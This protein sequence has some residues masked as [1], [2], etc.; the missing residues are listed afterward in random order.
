MQLDS[1]FSPL[2][3]KGQSIHHICANNKASVMFSKKTIYNYVDAGI[4]TARNIDMPRKARF[5][6][7]KSRHDSF[8]V[9]KTCRIGRTYKDFQLFMK[10]HPDSP[11]V[12]IDS[13]EGKK[14]EKVLLTIHFVKAEF[15]LAFLRERNTASSVS[16]IFEKLYQ[17]LGA[18]VFKKLFPL[19]LTD[20]GSEFSD[21]ESIERDADG[22]MR[23]RVFYCDPSAPHQ[24]GA[25]ENNHGFIR[26]V[27]PKGTSFEDLTQE[28]TDR[29]MCHIN[30]YCRANLGN[31]SPH[32]MF[33]LF[34][35]Q[36]VLD[37][38]GAVLI[39]PNDITL[40]PELLK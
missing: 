33:H 28:S 20:N 36:D 29:M 12:E 1:L 23:T 30:S 40:R 11:V 16:V 26:R 22:N 5:R 39:S 31:H 3:K 21:P 2:L 38:L 7:R 13:V 19:I 37:A 4:F 15:M 14:G 6:V 10:D 9:D 35:G 32:E 18:E 8:K 24:K 34:Y 27:L 25:V 17:T